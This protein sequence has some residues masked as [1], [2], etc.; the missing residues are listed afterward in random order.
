M[1]K[2]RILAIVGYI[3]FTVACVALLGVLWVSVNL[4]TFPCDSPED[5]RPCAEVVP[6]FFATRGLLPFGGLWALVTVATFRRRSR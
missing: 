1:T 2:G 3:A 4:L 5:P 6:W